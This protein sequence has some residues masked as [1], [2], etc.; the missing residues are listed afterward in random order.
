MS[1]GA[2]HWAAS[3]KAAKPQNSTS[4]NSEGKSLGGFSSLDL[5][6]HVSSLEQDDITATHMLKRCVFEKTEKQVYAEV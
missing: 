1:A 2:L 5:V 4:S 3:G 6:I